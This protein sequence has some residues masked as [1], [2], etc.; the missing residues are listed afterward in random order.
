MKRRRRNP[1]RAALRALDRMLLGPIMS[2]A[3]IVIERRVVGGI[4]KADPPTPSVDVSGQ[5]P[6]LS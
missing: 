4:K 6:K 1:F 2:L 3:A 5:R